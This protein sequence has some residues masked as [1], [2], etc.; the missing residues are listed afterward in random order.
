MN[1]E[2]SKKSR[3]HSLDE[4][5]A[6]RPH[7]YQRLH[8]IADLMDQAI[9]R[10]ATADEAEALVIEQIR[11]LGGELL[12]DWAKAS[13]DQALG[14]AREDHPRSSKHIKKSKV[15]HDLWSGGGRGTVAAPGAARKRTA[16]LL[17]KRRRGASGLLPP[18]ATG[19][20]TFWRGTFLYPGGPKSGGALRD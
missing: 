11:K 17:P 20:G 8:E 16:A 14:Q 9:A 12:G 19:V 5:F 1:D 2:L 18:L 6:H 4:R 13:H 3:P 15:V 7:T 10:G